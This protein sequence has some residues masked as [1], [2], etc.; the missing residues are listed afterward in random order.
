MVGPLLP[1]GGG[2]G[3]RDRLCGDDDDGEHRHH[4]AFDCC[5]PCCACDAVAA[6]VVVAGVVVPLPPWLEDAVTPWSAFVVRPSGC[7][8]GLKSR[9]ADRKQERRCSGVAGSYWVGR[10]VLDG[11]VASCGLHRWVL[12]AA[13]QTAWVVYAGSP[14]RSG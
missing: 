7:L 14:C 12:H 8:L 5:L 9:L 13:Q 10:P 11:A 3:T 6:V 1:T 2:D 4:H